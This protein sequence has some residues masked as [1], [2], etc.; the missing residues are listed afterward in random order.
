MPHI[1]VN[2]ATLHY[3]DQ[4]TG[5]ETIVFAHGLIWSGEMFAEQVAVLKEQYRCITFDFRGQGRSEVTATGYD[6]DTLAKDAACLIEKLTDH[7]VHFVGLS[8]G[9]FVAMRL[10]IRRPDL[11]KSLILLDTSADPEPEENVGKYNRLN[12][13]ARWIGLSLVA[14]KVMELMF[15]EKFLQDPIR[16]PIRQDMRDRIV[17]NHRIGITRAVKGVVTRDGIYNQLEGIQLP[18]LIIVGDQDVATEPR[19]S[20]RIHEKISGSQLQLIEGAGHTSTVEEPAAVNTAIQVFLGK[21]K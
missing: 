12:F 2:G 21:N 20:E 5:P 8:M 13:V 9:G 7:P 15:G 4:G 6:M 18:T 1:T 10:G 16:K 17:S 19:K 3:D 11:L 14:S